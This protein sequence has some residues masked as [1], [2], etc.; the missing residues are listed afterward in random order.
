MYL[1]VIFMVLIRLMRRLQ[2]MIY[3]VEMVLSW[4]HECYSLHGHAGA[5]E[6]AQRT[7]GH[8]YLIPTCDHHMRSTQK[9]ELIQTGLPPTDHSGDSDALGPI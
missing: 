5:Y 2:Q 6:G 9:E 4:L 8:L 7:L 1:S 3:N